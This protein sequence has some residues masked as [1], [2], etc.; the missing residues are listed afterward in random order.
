VRNTIAVYYALSELGIYYVFIQGRRASLSS[1]L[2]LAII[3]RAFG[4][5][6]SEF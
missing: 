4:A 5:A 6:L 2:A 3:F 1:A